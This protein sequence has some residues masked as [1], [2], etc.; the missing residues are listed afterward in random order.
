MVIKKNKNNLGAR[1]IDV[2]SEKSAAI[3]WNVKTLKI[4]SISLSSINNVHMASYIILWTLS[5]AISTLSQ[6][7]TE[8]DEHLAQIQGMLS[9]SE[10]QEMLFAS[11]DLGED[12]IHRPNSL[13]LERRALDIGRF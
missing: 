12:L 6:S 13:C 2:M 10:R 5:I 8:M 3:S 1:G 11:G 7:F 4:A 9:D